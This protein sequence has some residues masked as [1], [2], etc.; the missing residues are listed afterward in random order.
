MGA[1]D[2]RLLA[3][4]DVDAIL[5]AAVAA[6][7][8]LLVVDSIQTVRVDDL[9]SASGSV[10]Q[11]REASGRLIRF[12][13]EHHVPTVL[14]GHVTKDGGIAGPRMLEHMV[15]VVLYLE[16]DTDRG[17]R[18]LSGLKNRFG[19]TH[20]S[21]LFEMRHEGL[22]EIPDPSSV[23][24]EG[25]QTGAAGSVVFPSIQGRRTVLVEVQ[26][27]VGAN[28]VGPNPRRSVRGLDAAR[29]H[30]IA[31]VLERHVGFSLAEHDLYV[32]VQG[33]VQVREPEVDLAVAAALVSSHLDRPVGDVATWGE[34]GL[35]GEVRP[36][37]QSARR[38]EEAA[39]LGLR[40]VVPARPGPL[41]AA[42]AALDLR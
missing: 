20:T 36:A 23:F 27:L 41:A 17:L 16:G 39:R 31:A 10:A 13:K 37:S 9:P 40:A 12:A 35:T 15:D 25:R 4:D 5:A 22:V 14:V 33:G 7:P 1:G 30:Q 19:S 42:L 26:A 24:V 6:P 28:A 18:V 32:A 3:H 2:I 38:A 34:I 8:A 11:V 29:V 21:G